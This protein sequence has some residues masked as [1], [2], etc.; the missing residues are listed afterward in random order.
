MELRSSCS[1]VGI[2]QQLMGSTNLST[3]NNGSLR[4]MLF[5]CDYEFGLGPGDISMLSNGVHLLAGLVEAM[6]ELRRFFSVGLHGT[7]FGSTLE[8][9][10][11]TEAQ[12]ESLM[13]N[14]PINE[15]TTTAYDITEEKDATSALSSLLGIFTKGP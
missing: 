3:A 8:R 2:R 11:F 5:S 12:I 6:A 15:A 10:G 9:S 14:C 1:W 13:G 4:R 7:A